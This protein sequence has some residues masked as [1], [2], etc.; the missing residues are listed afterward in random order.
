M[1]GFFGSDWV[2]LKWFIQFMQSPFF[3]RLLKNTFLLGFYSLVF[4]FPAPILLALLLNEIH[5]GP[6]KRVAQSITYLPHFVSV[7]IM[8]GMLY[9]FFGHDGYVN[10]ILAGL[11]IGAVDFVNDSRWFRP[12]YV[13]SG[14][15][16]SI[17][18]GSIVFLASLA[19][20][21][22]ELYESSYLDG[23]Q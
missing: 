3:P 10:R 14:I 23:G 1:D 22:P 20:I 21:N 8:V 6:F 11:G 4:G 16:Q 19:S 9:S 15:W 18:W 13:I 7:V 2:G 17:G 12:I 5:Y